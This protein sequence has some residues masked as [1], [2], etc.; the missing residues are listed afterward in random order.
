MRSR[1]AIEH[2]A[3]APVIVYPHTRTPPDSATCGAHGYHL[4][5]VRGH[6][7]T[8]AFVPGHRAAPLHETKFRRK[9]L[10]AYHARTHTIEDSGTLLSRG[11]V[12]LR[13]TSARVLETRRKKN[14]R[15]YGTM[16]R[17]AIESIRYRRRRSGMDTNTN[18]EYTPRAAVLPPH[19]KWWRLGITARLVS[20]STPVQMVVPS[21]HNCPRS[22]APTPKLRHYTHGRSGTPPVLTAR[23]A[24]QR[25]QG[26]YTG[27]GGGVMRPAK[28]RLARSRSATLV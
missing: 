14:G 11:A 24:H 20:S 1:R 22:A 4:H 18:R 5:I 28:I 12:M 19:P 26:A 17:D 23:T 6:E 2:L 8:H 27:A 16:R 21:L 3:A 25:M 15:G 9:R 7:H 10:D 13:R